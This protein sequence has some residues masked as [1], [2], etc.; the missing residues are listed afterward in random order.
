MKKSRVA[1]KVQRQMRPGG[2]WRTVMTSPTRG[3]A[4]KRF[5]ALAA[6]LSGGSVMFLRD[7]GRE[8]MGEQ[9]LAVAEI[10][11]GLRVTWTGL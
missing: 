8:H 10:P 5:T 3:P 4:E 11:R 7:S 9:I 1:Y 2:S 6:R